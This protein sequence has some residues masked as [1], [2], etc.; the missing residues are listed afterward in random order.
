MQNSFQILCILNF[1]HILSKQ[2]KTLWNQD[3]NLSL[4]PL[5]INHST[6]KYIK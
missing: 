4:S 5:K 3:E 1:K 2:M 6:N